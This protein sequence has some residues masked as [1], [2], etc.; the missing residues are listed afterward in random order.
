VNALTVLVALGAAAV[1]GQSIEIGPPPGTLVDIGGRTLHAICSGTGAPTVILEAGAS[2][3][4]IDWTLVQ[5]DIA[6]TTR[7]CSYDRAGHG[8]SDRGPTP[9]PARIVADLHA[10]LAALGEK[11]PYILVGASAGGLYVRTYEH[12]YPGEVAGLVLVDPAHEDRLFTFFQGQAVAIGSLTADQLRATMPLQPVR[13]PR[14]KPQS[15]SPFD[16]L[17]PLLY[18]TRIALDEQLIASV[19]ET[20]TPDVIAESQ[21]GQRAALAALQALSAK[22][23]PALGEKPLIVLSAGIDL[24]AAKRDVHASLGRL[25]RNFRHTVVERAGHE[26]HLFQPDAVVRAIRDVVNAVRGG[27]RLD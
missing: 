20:V 17:P 16:R 11:P 8:W 7:I 6:K 24:P 15:G 13:V 3:F 26:V 10:L 21:E 1:A 4:A 23:D 22:A 12:T 18:K 19:P 9:T 14:R 25:T 2:S 5:P 27:N